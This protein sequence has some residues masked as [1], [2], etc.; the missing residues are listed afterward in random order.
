[1]RTSDCRGA[2]AAVRAVDSS[3]ASTRSPS[4]PAASA[5]SF[6]GSI[7]S[8]SRILRSPAMSHHPPAT[9]MADERITIQA[10]R[11]DGGCAREGGKG[12]QE[13]R[14]GGGVQGSYG[15][16]S[17]LSSYLIT[18]RLICS[19]PSRF[20]SR[21][22]LCTQSVSTLNHLTSSASRVSSSFFL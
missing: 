8:G 16:G 3:R 15:G 9:N 2:T 4:L 13:G 17:L 18:S 11:Y 6:P 7:A 20:C 19:R 10:G 22:R 12:A 21:Q 1:A 14:R 5:I